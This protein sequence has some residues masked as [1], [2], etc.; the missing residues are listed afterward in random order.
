MAEDI[1]KKMFAIYK[2]YW[3]EL[4]PYMGML[5]LPTL[6]LTLLGMTS[7]FLN[8][9]VPASSPF[10]NLTIVAVFAASLVFSFWATIALAKELRN[11]IEEK[12]VVGWK[13]IFTNSS[14]LI[15]PM[16]YTSILTTLIVFAGT[17][18]LI[19]P[20][21]IFA[22][23]YAFAFYELIYEEKKGW[24]ALKASKELVVG[25]W[26]AIVWR[27]TLPSLLVGL[28]AM[29]LQYAI[30]YPLNF[31]ITDT[32]VL[33]LTNSLLSTIINVAFAPLAAAATIILYLSAK[34]TTVALPPK[35]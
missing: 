3:K 16:I 30:S 9:Y 7:V 19:I 28:I 27:M 29:F 21:I 11:L 8:Y 15:W 12:P 35:V 10:T 18:L 23:W 14:R 20:G 13:N 24:S 34:Q 17:L 25:R 31:I 22:V 6:V 2:K 33:A 32:F 4:L 26:W 1:I 5:F